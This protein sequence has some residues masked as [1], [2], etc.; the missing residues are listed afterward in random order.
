[1]TIE[2]LRNNIDNI[3]K[4]LTKLLEARMNTVLEIA[5]LKKQENLPVLDSNR[6]KLLL[7]KIESFVENS[8]FI[9]AILAT[10]TDILKHSRDYQ[11]KKIG[12]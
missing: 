7:E 9:P 11:N 8:D 1:M 2:K 12:L 6:E 3:D 4:E 10:Y 5:E